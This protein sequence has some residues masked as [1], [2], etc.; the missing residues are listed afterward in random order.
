MVDFPKCSVL[1]SAC[2]AM[3]AYVSDLTCHSGYNIEHAVVDSSDLTTHSF[4]LATELSKQLEEEKSAR[5]SLTEEVNGLRAQVD[6][7]K[8]ENDQRECDKPVQFLFL[9]VLVWVLFWPC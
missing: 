3:C 2:V 8:R 9:R 4:F 6:K 1:E 5:E 7:L